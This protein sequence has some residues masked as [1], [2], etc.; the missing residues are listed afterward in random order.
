M[1]SCPEPQDEDG[2]L[3][4]EDVIDRLCLLVEEVHAHVGYQHASDC[5][6][7]KGGFWDIERYAANAAR[8]Q[9]DGFVLEWVEQV[10]RAKIK[11][12]TDAFNAEF[13]EIGE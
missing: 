10:V 3:T 8:Y 4:R 6:C 2:Q 5:F 13:P 12:E 9:N 1:E 7:K 11:E